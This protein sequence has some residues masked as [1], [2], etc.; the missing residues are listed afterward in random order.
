[1]I[2]LKAAEIVMICLKA[3]KKAEKLEEELARKQIRS[4]YITQYKICPDCGEDLTTEEP[5]P[6][7]DPWFWFINTPPQQLY[8]IY[9][10]KN[11]GEIKR[12]RI[13]PQP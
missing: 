2:C 1:M 6:Q 13:F 11:H 8:R 5:K 3:K 9:K 12:T 7:I 4:K 10:C